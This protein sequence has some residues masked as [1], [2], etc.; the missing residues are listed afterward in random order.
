[1]SIFVDTKKASQYD[2]ITF[3]KV[4]KM[5]RNKKKYIWKVFTKKKMFTII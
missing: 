3:L 5:F 2:K 1:M 4:I